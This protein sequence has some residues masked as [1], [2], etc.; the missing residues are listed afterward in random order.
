MDADSVEHVF[1]K[2]FFTFQRKHRIR[3]ESIGQV[4]WQD[5]RWGRHFIENVSLSTPS[6][7]LAYEYSKP[8]PYERKPTSESPIKYIV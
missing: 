5:Q 3:L 7:C 6:K 1:P 8:L 4:P 2:K